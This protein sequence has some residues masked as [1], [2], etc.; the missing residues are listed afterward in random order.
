MA[1][2]I[3]AALVLYA[4]YLLVLRPRSK[5]PRMPEEEARAI[6]GVT[7]DADDE[8]IRSAHRRLVSAVHP[9]KGGSAELTQRI[10]SARDTLLRH[11]R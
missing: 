6:L 1:K 4:L 9:D 7:A 10:N 8:A 11:G 2:L 5:G 3:L